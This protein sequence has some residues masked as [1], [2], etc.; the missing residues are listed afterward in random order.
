MIK[1]LLGIKKIEDELNILK[2]AMEGMKT[3][4]ILLLLEARI[5]PEKFIELLKS[6]EEDVKQFK[7]KVV[8]ILETNY[9]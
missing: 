7:E 9:E 5:T 1:K 2:V 6:Y 3:V 4:Q 8:E